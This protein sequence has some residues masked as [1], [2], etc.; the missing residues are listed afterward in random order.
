MLVSGITERRDKVGQ[1][2][3]WGHDVDVEPDE[4]ISGMQAC[5]GH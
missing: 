3:H 2:G 4:R 5:K 1:K